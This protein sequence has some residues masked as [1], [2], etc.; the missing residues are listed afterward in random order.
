[1]PDPGSTSAVTPKFKCKGHSQEGEGIPVLIVDDFV[2]DL[3]NHSGWSVC[4]NPHTDAQL[5]S[6]SDDSVI[7]H[8]D[9]RK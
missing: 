7:C 2:A 3:C 4:W 6:G 1:M 5:L 8:W 9:L